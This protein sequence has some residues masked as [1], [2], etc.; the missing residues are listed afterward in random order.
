MFLGCPRHNWPG[1]IEKSNLSYQVWSHEGSTLK[2]KVT[3]NSQN[4]RPA[5]TDPYVVLSISESVSQ[6]SITFTCNYSLS[7]APLHC[8]M[9]RSF[10]SEV[11]IQRSNLKCPAHSDING[12]LEAA[13][14][15]GR[16]RSMLNPIFVSREMVMNS[17]SN[18]HHQDQLV[19]NGQD[20]DHDSICAFCSDVLF[21]IWPFWIAM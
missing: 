16:R 10:C 13:L 11:S 18:F 6:E 17:K 5:E 14:Q 4:S 8:F 19:A 2:K 21:Y 9:F 20:D 15:P 3:R 7:L 12:D 1:T